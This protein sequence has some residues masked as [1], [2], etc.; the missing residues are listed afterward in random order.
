LS[1]AAWVGAYLA[2]GGAALLVV[3]LIVALPMVVRL[4]RRL[5]ALGRIW[6]AEQASI[7]SAL[8]EMRASGIERAALLRPYRRVWRLYRHP[9]SRAYA[10]SR[11]RRRRAVR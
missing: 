1:T 11:R 2:I 9:L 8:D 7:E 4:R 5:R 10:D 6:S 3:E